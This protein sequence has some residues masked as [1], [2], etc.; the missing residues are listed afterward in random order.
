MTQKNS[1]SFLMPDESKL[2]QMIN[3]VLAKAKNKGAT[4]AEAGLSMSQGLSVTARMREAETI[5]LQQD[6]G[7][8][9][10]VYFGKNKGTASTSNLDEGALQATLE[11]ACNIAKYTSD[12]EFSGL[13]DKQLMAT[14]IPDL[15]LYHPW[16]IDSEHAMQMALECEAA[17][18]DYDSKVSN[19]EGAS[20]DTGVSLSVYGNSHGFIAAQA[21]SRHSISCSVIA[22]KDGSMQRDYWYDSK[23]IAN[24]LEAVHLIGQK[25]AERT[26]KRLD[27]QKLKTQTA[28]I[29][30][31]N[32]MARGIISHVF[33][34]ISG[35][36]QYRKAS[37][38]LDK[39]DHVILPEW[40][41]INEDPFILQGLSSSAFDGEGVATKKSDI[42]TNG[43][44]NT[45]LLGS[46]SA[47]K[48]GRQ[49]TGH[50]GGVR[51]ISVSHGY[52]DL[53]AMLKTL[54][55]GLYVTELMGQGVN[56]ITGD[57]S[58]GA[59]GFWVENGAIQYP[60][61]EVTIAGNLNDMLKQIVEIGAD[62]DKRSSLHVGSLLIEE[63]MVAGSE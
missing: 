25:T 2:K 24:Q 8:G 16:D 43:Q 45:Y 1:N 19:S 52:K 3:D 7:L 18:L 5:E 49:S 63:M 41:S 48:L 37:F 9:I 59:A 17:A 39:I 21:K 30:F 12:D 13:A 14:N 55:K 29:L 60:V 58:R 26:L 38:L 46:Y 34:A 50:A 27:A 53:D 31:S 33:G 35:S 4:Q 23:R 15:D 44:L 36:A 62:I 10:T 32:E 61:E 6:N 42:V 11:A 54:D 40:L 28:P 57:Y 51:N 56:T 47:R 20:V 22:E